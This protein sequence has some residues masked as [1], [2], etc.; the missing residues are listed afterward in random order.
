MLA[1]TGGFGSSQ[2]AESWQPLVAAD[3]VRLAREHGL[4]R[5]ARAVPGWARQCASPDGGG[6]DCTVAL[7]VNPG[8]TLAGTAKR[9]H[10]PFRH[11]KIFYRTS[12]GA[13]FRGQ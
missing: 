13:C 4:G 7:A 2:P 12:G 3:L 1:A 6:D 10:R 11:Q 8:V 9:N 5:L